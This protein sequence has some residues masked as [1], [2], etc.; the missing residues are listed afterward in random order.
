MIKV[1]LLGAGNVAIHLAKA[2]VKA[3]NIN[4]VQRYR[5]NDKNDSFFDYSIPF[6]DKLHELIRADVYIIA[7][8]DDSLSAFSEKLPVLKGLVVHTSGS[9]S[10]KSLSD[11]LR[12]G[13]F[14]P[15]QSF[16]KDQK[17]DFKNIPI[18]IET[19]FKKDKELIE[20]L[21]S[22]ISNYVYSIDSKQREKLHLAAVFANNFSNFMFTIAKDLSDEYNFPF[23]ILKPL[24]LE[25]ANKIQVTDPRKAQTGPAIR[26][27]KKVI[28]KHLSQLKGEKKEIYKL[29][30]ESIMK[31]S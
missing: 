30:S 1:V 19:E 27:D 6:T 8:N 20:K 13:V 17:L 2:F 5:R 21:A 15:L 26:N 11:K 23:D 9:I 18:T 31:S 29:I 12:R 22:S 10:L 3:G 7:I 16:S 4:F 14:Y 28:D 24:I 25:T